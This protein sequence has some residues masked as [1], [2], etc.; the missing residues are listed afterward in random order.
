MLKDG[1]TSLADLVHEINNLIE[2]QKY[3]DAYKLVLGHL[4]DSRF[5]SSDVYYVC[6]RLCLSIEVTEN[7]M[8]F[9]LTLDIGLQKRV[10][11]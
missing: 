9:I 6:S 1:F 8:N 2:S 10:I 11:H 4:P 5:Q 3:E 7:S